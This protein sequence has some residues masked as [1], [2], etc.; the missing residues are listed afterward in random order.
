MACSQGDAMGLLSQIY[1]I[2]VTSRIWNE[3]WSANRKVNKKQTQRLI[4]YAR[5]F[6]KLASSEAVWQAWVRLMEK[7]NYQDSSKSLCVSYRN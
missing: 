1:T 4:I 6:L 7:G 5:N 3:R 2:F